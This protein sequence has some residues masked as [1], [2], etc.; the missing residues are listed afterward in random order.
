MEELEKINEVIEYVPVRNITE[1]NNTFFVTAEIVK[2]KMAKNRREYREP[3]WKRG[4]KEKVLELQKDI[5]E[6]KEAMK[7]RY[8]DRMRMK[9]GE[10]I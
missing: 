7:R 1:L 10:E 5:S 4:L 6:V 2:Q 9:I 3:P 8:N